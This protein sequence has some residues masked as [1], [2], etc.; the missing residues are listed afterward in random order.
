MGGTFFLSEF[1]RHSSEKKK[2]VKFDE[3]KTRP[4][5]N[6]Y[7]LSTTGKCQY[8]STCQNEI[9]TVKK[10]KKKKLTVLF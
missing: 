7:K 10:E 1:H 2:K 6:E 9:R 5:V 4:I 3:I 8:S